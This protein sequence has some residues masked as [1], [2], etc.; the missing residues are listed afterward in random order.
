[1]ASPLLVSVAAIVCAH[2]RAG[3]GLFIRS[4]CAIPVLIFTSGVF[5]LQE[6][7]VTLELVS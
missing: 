2:F 3:L 5:L 7:P 6:M 4:R 1:V